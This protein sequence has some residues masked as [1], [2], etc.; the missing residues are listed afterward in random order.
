MG[1]VVLSPQP[2]LLPGKQGKLGIVQWAAR[3]DDR[4]E[5]DGGEGEDEEN[6]SPLVSLRNM[7]TSGPQICGM[8]D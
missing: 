3:M 8:S 7:L 5:G 2:I 6:P 4:A 1:S